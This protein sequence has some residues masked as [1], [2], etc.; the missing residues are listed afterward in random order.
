MTPDT[1]ALPRSRPEWRAWVR[2]ADPGKARRRAG[3]RQDH[4]AARL[5]VAVSVL[6]AWERGLRIPSGGRAATAWHQ[7]VTEMAAADIAPASTPAELR[8][9]IAAL[10]PEADAGVVEALAGVAEDHAAALLGGRHPACARWLPVA[11][12][13][14][15][16][17]ARHTG[18][19]M[20]VGAAV[21]QR[22]Q[23]KKRAVARIGAQGTEAA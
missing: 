4:L 10:V 20:S 11:L 8:L 7:E 14:C 19:C 13:A 3:V 16:L 18:P 22:M 12:S 5:G 21:N 2:L 23:S 17:A 15:G 1:S 6:G 9:K